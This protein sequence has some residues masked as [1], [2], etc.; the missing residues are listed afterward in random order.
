ML[1]LLN[2]VV[3]AVALIIVLAIAAV[4]SAPNPLDLSTDLTPGNLSWSKPYGPNSRSLA[5][6]SAQKAVTRTMG[7]N[8]NL[9]S[10]AGMQ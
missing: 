10:A 9:V 7:P 1:I 2:V 8:L 5:H 3:I 6:M 4:A